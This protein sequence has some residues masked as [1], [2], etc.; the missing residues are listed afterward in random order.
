MLERRRSS[1][2]SVRIPVTVLSR[3][4]EGQPVATSAEAV[5][6]SR[7]G[8]LI[9]V[10]SAVDLGARFEVLHIHSQETREFRV[11]RVSERKPDGWFELGVEILF[12][13]RNFWRVSFPDESRAN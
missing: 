3:D 10:P 5:G 13:N 9:R 6:I 2:I 7:C 1:R 11:V 12:P 4:S 8:A